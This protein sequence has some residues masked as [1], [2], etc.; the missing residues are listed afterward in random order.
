MPTILGGLQ[1]NRATGTAS[2]EVLVS[3]LHPVHQA[4]L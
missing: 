2:I 3:P 4:G 1:I